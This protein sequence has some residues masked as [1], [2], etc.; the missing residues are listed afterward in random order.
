MLSAFTLLVAFLAAP[1]HAFVPATPTNDVASLDSF[2]DGNL[3]A[4]WNPPGR[5]DGITKIVSPKPNT[6]KSEIGAFVNF[7]DAMGESATDASVTPWIAF[8]SCDNTGNA[9]DE[10]VLTRA[11]EL[12]AIGALLYS[13]SEATCALDASFENPG[14]DVH[15]LL[16][17]PDVINNLPFLLDAFNKIDAIYRNFD[18][19]TLATEQQN[20]S[21]AVPGFFDIDT[22]YILG[23]LFYL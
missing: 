19:A 17:A 18:A 8:V 10:D 15:T 11:H 20:I 2:P 5:F 4:F 12:G 1:V 16:P 14:Y 6:T 3:Q 9:A 21:M 22:G 23:S 7:N 13:E